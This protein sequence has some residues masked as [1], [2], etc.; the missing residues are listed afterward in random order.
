MF[1]VAAQPSD[2]VRTAPSDNAHAKV[3]RVRPYHLICPFLRR[4]TTTEEILSHCV[5]WCF[6]LVCLRAA[7]GLSFSDPLG[8]RKLAMDSEIGMVVIFSGF[9]FQTS[10]RPLEGVRP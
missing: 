7:Y 6:S 8:V 5:V 2:T 1:S 10:A 3:P 9:C 4:T